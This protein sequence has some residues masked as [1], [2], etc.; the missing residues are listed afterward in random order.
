MTLSRR[1]TIGMIAELAGIAA[2]IAFMLG[3]P[4]FSPSPTYY[5]NVEGG[6]Q[7][8][9]CNGGIAGGPELPTSFSA[10]G[11]VATVTVQGRQMPLRFTGTELFFDVYRNGPYKLTLDPEANLIGPNGLRLTNC[12][13]QP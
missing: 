12:A 4:P 9:G 1:K 10:D 2:L 7:V 13:T 3:L 5:E 6:A 8:Y 11:K